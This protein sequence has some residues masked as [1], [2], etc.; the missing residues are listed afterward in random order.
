MFS[1]KTERLLKR[2]GY[3]KAVPVGAVL[4]G[5]LCVIFIIY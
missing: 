5:E 2:M 4:Y 3:L 1:L